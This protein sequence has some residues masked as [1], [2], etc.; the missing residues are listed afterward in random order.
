[1]NILYHHRTMGR[2]AEGVHIASIV[3]AFEKLGHKVIVVSPAGVDPI[4][5]VG[6]RPLDKSDEET[7][8]INTIWKFISKK[9]P[10][11]LFEL[12]EMIYNIVA[13]QKIHKLIKKQN[14]DLIYERNANFLFS[15]AFVASKFNIPL[16]IE[17]NEVAGLVRARKLILKPIALLI[18]KYTFNRSKAIFTVSSYL[19]N[20]ICHMGIP[21]SNVHLM[22]NAIEPE[23]FLKKTERHA[24]R[25]KFKIEDNIVLGFVGWFDWWDRLDLLVDVQKKL[26]ESG[27]DNVSTV[28]I[29][30]GPVVKELKIKINELDISEK[31]IFTGPVP[32][33][34]VISY[35]DAIDICVLPHSNDFGSPI[36]LF[37]MM[38]L[39]KVI[40]APSLL[41]ITDVIRHGVN[42]IIFTPLDLRSLLE[43]IIKVIDDRKLA[44]GLGVTAQHDVFQHYTWTKNAESIISI[45]IANKKR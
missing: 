30:D 27:Y 23:K 10:Q 26:V 22:P 21:S 38:A 7:K 20:R 41:P 5:T 35:I 32:R 28:L 19:V 29:G 11:I 15:G 31:V 44:N 36:V 6:G 45:A 18:E 42:G 24:I 13:I 2:G 39:G 12:F 40:V 25:Q 37:E 4:K 16:I 34:K 8:G 3:K 14:I 1:M 9:A 43:E 17:A 33:E